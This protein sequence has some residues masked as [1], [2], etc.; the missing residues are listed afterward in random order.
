M[1][2]P[3]EAKVSTGSTSGG[4]PIS[5]GTTTG[6]GTAVALASTADAH[7]VEPDL[8][9]PDHGSGRPG[10]AT[11][12]G[13][14]TTVSIVRGAWEVRL[15]RVDGPVDEAATA[16][17]IGGWAAGPGLVSA[18]VPLLGDIAPVCGET[19]SE[20]ATPLAGPTTT[21]WLRYAPVPAGW[22][23][24]AVHLA[25]TPAVRHPQLELTAGQATVTWADGKRTTAD[26]P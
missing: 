6:G 20:D 16:L 21:P 13:R 19:E 1:V 22:V 23:A 8:T 2:A 25:R 17:R 24:A 4:A 18:L 7:W 3:V 5:V 14:I 15:V 10:S 11:S 9:A 12:A 26:L